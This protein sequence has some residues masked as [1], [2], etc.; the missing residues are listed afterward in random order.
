M[1]KEQWL[2][3]EKSPTLENDSRKDIY[4]KFIVWETIDMKEKTASGRS[5]C[6]YL[7]CGSG[8][9]YDWSF[10]IDLNWSEKEYCMQREKIKKEVKQEV[11]LLQLV[12]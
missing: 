7:N 3:M 10:T 11:L 1:N 8:D 9:V 6:G 5:Y 12:F 4:P 2:S